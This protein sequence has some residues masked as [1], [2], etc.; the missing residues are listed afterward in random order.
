MFFGVC[1]GLA[2]YFGVDPTLIRLAFVLLFFF[3]GTGVLAY[4]VLAFVMP[5]ADAGTTGS[6]DGATAAASHASGQGFQ[7]EQGKAAPGSAPRRLYRIREGR[8]IEGVCTGLAAYL[9][10]DPTLIRLVF[11]SLVFLG[12]AGAFAVKHYGLAPIFWLVVTGGYGVGAYVVMACLMPEAKTPEEKAAASGFQPTA[13]EFIRRAKEGY[14]EAMKNFPDRKTRR[15]WSRRFKWQARAWRSYWP[16]WHGYWHSGCTDPMPVHPGMGFLVP[17]LSLLQGALTVLWLC[18]LVSLLAN[19]ALFGL[20][21]PTGMPVWLAT[22]VLLMGYL[23]IKAPLKAARHSC[24]MGCGGPGQTWPVILLVDALVWLLV[25]ATLVWLGVHYS[26]Q[27]QSALENLPPVA[28]Q[29]AQDVRG[30]WKGN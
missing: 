11:V 13:Q 15:E 8:I 28:H 3:G 19:G 9:N 7:G 22:M 4:I 21:V 16:D 25:F 30:W 20:A 29:A 12:L 1:N 23:A 6:A 27:L 24:H 18:A 10:I 5:E 14:Y 17:I 26:S 2:T